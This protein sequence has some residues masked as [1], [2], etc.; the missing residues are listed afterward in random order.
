[1]DMEMKKEMLKNV[2]K[3]LFGYLEEN[4]DLPTLYKVVNTLNQIGNGQVI[5]L[6]KTVP[7]YKKVDYCEIEMLVG[8]E[9]YIERNDG[10][11]KVIVYEMMVEI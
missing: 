2:E 4:N 11:D 8:Q 6:L 9:F 3:A 1:M 7:F 5:Y 10:E